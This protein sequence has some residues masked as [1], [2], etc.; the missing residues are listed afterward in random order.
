M[1]DVDL[2]SSSRGAV[3]LD[4]PVAV[5][6]GISGILE[7]ANLLSLLTQITLCI[8]W[9]C[10]AFT[11]RTVSLFRLTKQKRLCKYLDAG[12]P[13]VVQRGSPW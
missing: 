10:I 6:F 8:C 2:V 4:Y 12:Q 3:A 7:A 9:K 11:P 1:S 13:E 5:H